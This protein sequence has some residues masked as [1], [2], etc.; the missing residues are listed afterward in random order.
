M[1]HV[2]VDSEEIGTST[3]RST[4]MRWSQKTARRGGLFAGD[5]LSSMREKEEDV[6]FSRQV[7]PPCREHTVSSPPGWTPGTGEMGSA[8]WA[9]AR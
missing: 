6:V 3:R 2:P 8:W 7:G 1:L 5:A 9:A 4:V